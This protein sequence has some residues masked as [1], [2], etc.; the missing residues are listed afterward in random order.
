MVNSISSDPQAAS[1]IRENLIS[2]SGVMRDGKFKTEDYVNAVAYV[3]YKIMGYT[4]QESY[5][6]TFP[7]RYQALMA[8]APPP[9]TSRP[10]SPPT[11]KTSWST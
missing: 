8:G 11:T 10:M 3:S 4:N 9:K 5:Q 6:R 1:T 7:S 2:Y